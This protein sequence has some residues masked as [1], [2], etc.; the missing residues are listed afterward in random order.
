MKRIHLHGPAADNAGNFCDAGEDLDVSAS[1][2]AGHIDEDRAKAMVSS[3]GAHVIAVAATQK[4]KKPAAPKK[5]P[6]KA[7]AAR[8]K[9]AAPDPVVV[10][11]QSAGQTAEALAQSDKPPLA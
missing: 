11:R 6:R 9:K 3:G 1:A 4:A 7:R 5:A 2:K 8:P 10:Q